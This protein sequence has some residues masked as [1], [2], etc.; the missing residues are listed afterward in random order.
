MSEKSTKK[1]IASS[2]ILNGVI[3]I[4]LSSL[5]FFFS[6]AALITLI[7]IFTVIILL[8]GT[9]RVFVSINNDDLS[10]AGKATKFISGFLLIILS[11]V[12]FI[13]TLGDP[14]FS[15]TLL[16]FFLTVGLLIIGLARVGTGAV[17]ETFIKAFRIYLIIIGLITIILNLIV[18]IAVNLDAIIKID[19]IATSLL[20]NGFTRFLYGL[21]GQEKFRK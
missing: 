17:N 19:L 2:N 15:T 21:M 7:Y 4:I 5:I 13:I 12:V 18:I 16:I 14:T 11:F 9:S 8:S 1:G 20:I 6:S 3:T 10:N